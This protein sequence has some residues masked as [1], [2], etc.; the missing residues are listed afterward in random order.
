MRGLF[1]FPPRQRRHPCEQDHDQ[2]Q[3]RLPAT[4]P[5][6]Q[7]KRRLRLEWRQLPQRDG[8]SRNGCTH[9]RSRTSRCRRCTWC[10]N[11]AA[12]GARGVTRRE[13]GSALRDCGGCCGGHDHGNAGRE[14]GAGTRSDGCVSRPCGR[15]NDLRWPHARRE[16][17]HAGVDGAV[18][19]MAR[20]GHRRGD[21]YRRRLH[22]LA[23]DEQPARRDRGW[24]GEPRT[25]AGVR[26]DAAAQSECRRHAGCLPRVD[27]GAKQR[28]RE[29]WVVVRGRQVL[30][31]LVCAPDGR[32]VDLLAGFPN[33]GGRCSY[34]GRPVAY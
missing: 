31:R 29:S 30:R 28:R 20:R 21:G 26:L 25:E 11:G 1:R 32:A 34:S 16:A 27:R 7:R 2:C 5:T 15:G 17:G 6:A 13:R 23:A 24:R 8:V 14:V 9:P 22:H 10:G 12:S 4:L 19:G 18:R 3:L 33:R